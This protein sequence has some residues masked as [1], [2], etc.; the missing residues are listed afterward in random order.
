M[1]C[2]CLHVF[3]TG[4]AMLCY[5]VLCLMLCCA[6][7]MLCCAVLTAAVEAQRIVQGELNINGLPGLTP[8]HMTL[9]GIN[10]TDLPALVAEHGAEETEALVKSQHSANSSAAGVC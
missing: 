1:R 4:D 7:L 8:A 5:A 9:A 3:G 2:A 6:M 10:C